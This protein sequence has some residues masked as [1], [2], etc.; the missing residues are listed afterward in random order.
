MF[1]PVLMTA[2]LLV[3]QPAAPADLENQVRDLVRQLN[4]DSKDERDAAQ[5][6][7]LE[8]GPPILDQ[9][10][11]PNSRM[12]AEMR[13]RVERIRLQL[14][15]KRAE[16]SVDGTRVTLKVDK[17]PLSE[18]LAMLE[19]LSGNQIVSRLPV[20]EDG[21]GGGAAEPTITLDVKDAPFLQVL[22]QVLDQARLTLDIFATTDDGKPLKSLVVM[23]PLAP[24]LPRAARSNYSGAFRFEPLSITSKRGLA[25]PAESVLQVLIEAQWEPRLAPITMTFPRES[26][27]IKF[28]DGTKAGSARQGSELLGTRA[29]GSRFPLH[30]ELPPR[31][32]A[33]IEQITGNLKVLLP[34]RM[35]TFRFGPLPGPGKYKEQ[36]AEVTVFVDRV[37]KNADA[38]EVFVRLKFDDAAG[39]LQSHLLDWVEDNP[40][41]LESADGK[42]MEPGSYQPTQEGENEYG[43]SY[44]FPLAGDIKGYTFVYS[45]P[46][47][48]VEK[49][50]PFEIKNL[51]L[52]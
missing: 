19:K 23:A 13:Q 26:L 1:A 32:A 16:T 36:K 7:L 51:D 9:L 22:D 21:Q 42:K 30:I 2:F 41:W 33:R 15:Q 47:A 43:I 3:A 37:A 20:P 48:L 6:Q 50:I 17:R 10:P 4:A 24:L 35:E 52:P 49:T 46:A 45:T 40:A 29:A 14:E 38:W 12:P 28:D 31:K 25:D 27:A 11:I 5:K 34:G 8:L 39:A 44:L 18:V